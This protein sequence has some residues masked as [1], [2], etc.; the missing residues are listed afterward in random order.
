MTICFYNDSAELLFKEGSKLKSNFVGGTYE[1]NYF[2]IALFDELKFFPHFQKG[3]SI[4]HYIPNQCSSCQDSSD[5]EPESTQENEEFVLPGYKKINLTCFRGRFKNFD[6]FLANLTEIC[7]TNS[8]VKPD[9]DFGNYFEVIREPLNEEIYDINY[10]SYAGPK[11]NRSLGFV[12]HNQSLDQKIGEFFS[13]ILEKGRRVQ[14]KKDHSDY[15]FRGRELVSLN[16]DF[17]EIQM[18]QQIYLNPLMR[19]TTFTI[20]PHSKLTIPAIHFYPQKTKSTNAI[21]IIKNNLTGI[22]MVSLKGIGGCGKLEFIEVRRQVPINSERFERI[23]IFLLTHNFLIMIPFQ[24][25]SLH[26]ILTKRIAI[27]FLSILIKLNLRL[28]MS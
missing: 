20:L 14:Q 15:M 28:S 10:M 16:P 1:S 12:P 26:I 7:Q 21:L 27:V 13:Q 23:V 5:S 24:K 17:K 4:A 3:Y 19:E 8:I 11:P 18:D 9:P 22:H 2:T 6:G 25:I